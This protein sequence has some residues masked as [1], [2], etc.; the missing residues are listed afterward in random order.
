MTPM[1]TDDAIRSAL[2]PGAEI[3]APPEFMGDLM[4]RIAANPAQGGRF[5]AQSWRPT[6]RLAM[7]LALVILLILALVLSAFVIGNLTK[8]GGPNGVVAAIEN[9]QVVT[10]DP[11]TGEAFATVSEFAEPAGL[12]RSPDGSTLAFWSRV[13]GAW[14]PWTMRADGTTQTRLANN[15]ASISMQPGGMIYSENGL[16]LTSGAKVDGVDRI[17]VIDL[18]SGDGTLLGPPEGAG[19]HVPSPNGDRIA[20]NFSHGQGHHTIAVMTADGEDLTDLTTEL[21]ADSGGADSWSPDGKW[22]YFGAGGPQVDSEGHGYTASTVYRVNVETREIEPLTHDQVAAAP[23]LSPDGTLVAYMAWSDPNTPP[24][25]WVMNADG[26]GAHLLRE[27]ADIRGWSGDNNYVL[28]EFNAGGFEARLVAIPVAGGADQIITT[29]AEC[30]SP[31]CF[32]DV[33]WG[34]PRP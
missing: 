9:G 19:G 2:R 31:P 24:D 29:N 10:L 6:L 1:L 18:G 33:S 22:I 21:A 25:L 12:G 11:R 15:L 4:K 16:L 13:D 17:L 26:G 3:A 8:L 28:V 23:A 27:K 7:Q 5:G 34:H 32:S 30:W 14:R 20:F